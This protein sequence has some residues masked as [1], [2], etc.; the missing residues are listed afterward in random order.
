RPVTGFSFKVLEPDKRR[1]PKHHIIRGSN[2]DLAKKL[3]EVSCEPYLL[4]GGTLRSDLCLL[5]LVLEELNSSD[6]PLAV[7]MARRHLNE[8]AVP[9]T[10][11]K[12]RFTSRADSPRG[13]KLSERQWRVIP[14]TPLLE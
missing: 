11:L 14:P 12:N 3:E 8:I 7:E 10:R 5:K 2:S 13:Q 6:L 4:R 9:A 1:I